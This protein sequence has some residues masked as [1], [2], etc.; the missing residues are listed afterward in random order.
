MHVLKLLGGISSTVAI[1]AVVLGMSPVAASAAGPGTATS[2]LTNVSTGYVADSTGNAE[3]TSNAEFTVMP[4]TLTLN[5]VPNV[6]L[7][8]TSVKSIASGNADLTVTD[9]APTAGTAYDGNNNGTLN[10]TDYRGNSAGWSV[11]VGMGPFTSGSS[12]VSDATLTLDQTTGALD[13]TA[14]AVPTSVKLSQS[15]VSNDWIS[16]PQLLWD[17]AAGTGQGDNTATTA[18]TS[19][20]QITKQAN[21]AA[22]TYD[23]T[24]YWALQ[25]APAATTPAS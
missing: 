15:T 2:N 3:A 4:G 13:N 8:N 21:I 1:A 12:T 7:E 5:Q 20:L 24:L 19:N 9:T 23:A 14:T 11:T 18:A 25:N 6:V 17:A 22:G 10:V 16:N